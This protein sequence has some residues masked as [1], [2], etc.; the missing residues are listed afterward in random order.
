MSCRIETT[1]SFLKDLKRLAK[2]YPS[3][4]NDLKE[5]KETLEKNPCEGTLIGENI[6]KIRL[7]IESKGKGKSGG[8]RVIT[9]LYAIKKVLYL[10]AIYDK[11][12]ME[13]IRDSE[14]KERLSILL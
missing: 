3:I 8:A 4:K 11:S 13:N 14:I 12:D 1:E 6:Y 2:K 7:A 5:L 9:F 10:L